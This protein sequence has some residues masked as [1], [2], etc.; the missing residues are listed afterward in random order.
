MEDKE[1]K[2]ATSRQRKINILHKAN[3]DH[4]TN[5]DI[6]SNEK[7]SSSSALP[8]AVDESEQKEKY[9]LSPAFKHLNHLA[10]Y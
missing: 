6:A 4:V 1:S 7:I 5:T 10:I 2:K 9:Y 3:G 8:F